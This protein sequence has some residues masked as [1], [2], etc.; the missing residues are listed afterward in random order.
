MASVFLIQNQ[1]DHVLFFCWLKVIQAPIYLIQAIWTILQPLT[2]TG[3][4][5]GVIDYS[6]GGEGGKRPDRCAAV[7]KWLLCEESGSS[8]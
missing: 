4:A 2:R 3:A 1:L 8:I 6:P 5:E 7:I